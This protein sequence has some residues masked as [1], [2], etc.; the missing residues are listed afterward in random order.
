[1]VAL[2]PFP[3]VCSPDEP[4]QSFIHTPRHPHNHQPNP[5]LAPADVEALGFTELRDALLDLAPLDAK[6]VRRRRR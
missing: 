4:C 3:T 5:Q 6:H 2:L 1:M